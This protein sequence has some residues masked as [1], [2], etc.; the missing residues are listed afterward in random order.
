MNKKVDIL[1]ETK[2]ILLCLHVSHIMCNSFGNVPDNLPKNDNSW[3]QTVTNWLQT[4]Y[5][6][7]FM[8]YQ[9][10]I[11]IVFLIFK[12]HRPIELT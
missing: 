9:L 1:Q 12:K 6:S 3:L 4:G 11:E 7:N 5:S 10:F 2:H 8:T